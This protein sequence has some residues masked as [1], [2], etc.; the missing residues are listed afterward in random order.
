MLYIYC[1][2]LFLISYLIYLIIKYS[3]SEKPQYTL[4]YFRDKEFI[5]YP[6]IIAGFLNKMKI[7]ESHFVATAL[8]LIVKGY[9]NLEK[10]VDNTDYIFTI[11]KKIK[12][13]EIE[14]TALKVFF[15]SELNIGSK[16][17]LKQFKKIMKNEK[18]YGNYGRL[19]RIF[20]SDIREY[21]DK[22]QDVKKITNSTNIKNIIMCYVLY[23]IICFILK[24]Q[25]AH[26]KDEDV[27]LV[28][29]CGTIAFGFFSI[30]LGFIKFSILGIFSYT[31]SIILTSILIQT[32]FFSLVWIGIEDFLLMFFILILMAII[33][34]FD[35]MLQRK[36]TNLANACQMVKGLRNYIID[37]SNINEYNLNNVHLWDEY[38]VYAVAFNIIKNFF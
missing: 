37:Y 36:K 25:N 5:K 18:L 24:S 15:N 8:Y 23:M 22:K 26:I 35:D 3:G 14:T 16:Q 13:S 9:I 12:A 4:Q 33:M 29:V 11:V 2:I 19:K 31:I 1:I 34:I 21:F 32:I 38:Y 17:T 7:S 28:F 30:V 10:T 27:F 6:P 20:N